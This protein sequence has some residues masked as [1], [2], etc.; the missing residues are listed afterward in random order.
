MQILI[1]STKAQKDSDGNIRR[2]SSAPSYDSSLGAIFPYFTKLNDEQATELGA[3]LSRGY[4]EQF[5]MFT[6]TSFA[7]V[8]TFDREYSRIL[9]LSAS[10]VELLKLHPDLYT[11]I[12]IDE[13]LNES[14]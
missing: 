11:L 2:F 8:V 10:S 5:R 12:F 6:P 9:W 14:E 4:N 7:L 1:N 3:L 13:A